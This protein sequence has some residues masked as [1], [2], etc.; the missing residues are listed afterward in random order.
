MSLDQDRMKEARKYHM[1]ETIK[2]V[3]VFARK[4]PTPEDRAV[5][6]EL[7]GELL[8]VEERWTAAGMLPGSQMELA[9]GNHGK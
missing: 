6:A 2:E 9:N 1:G 3:K 8:K 4:A 7:E 5:L